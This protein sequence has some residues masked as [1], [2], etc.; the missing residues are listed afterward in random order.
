[1]L[2]R[3]LTRIAMLGVAVVL[4]QACGGGDDAA[5]D[6]GR[7]LTI[8]EQYTDRTHQ[9]C[10][11]EPGEKAT[12]RLACDD[13]VAIGCEGKLACTFYTDDDLVTYAC[14]SAP[15]CGQC[16]RQG[17]SGLELWCHDHLIG[18]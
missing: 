9:L 14:Q 3:G 12:Y 7:C 13:H 1:M 15:T 18:D 6:D 11:K 2:F 10:C 5:A 8:K 16:A 17:D 4:S